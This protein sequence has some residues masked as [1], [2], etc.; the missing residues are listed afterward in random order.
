MMI[1]A[2]RLFVG[3]F[4]C[5]PSVLLMVLAPEVLVVVIG[6]VIFVVSFYAVGEW[7]LGG[8]DD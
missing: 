8:G 4:I 2:K 6:A 3:T 7:V 1:H 5:G